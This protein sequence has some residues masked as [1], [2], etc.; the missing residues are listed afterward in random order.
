MGVVS[1]GRHSLVWMDRLQ[2]GLMV[3][4]LRYGMFES[5][6]STGGAGQI[7]VTVLKQLCC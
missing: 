6:N 2:Q 7:R 4:Q 5:S 1:I 3:S